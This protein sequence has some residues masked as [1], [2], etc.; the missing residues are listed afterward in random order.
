MLFNYRALGLNPL[1]C[2][3]NLAWFSTWI[4]NDYVEPGIARCQGPVLLSNKLIL[5]TPTALFECRSNL[6]CQ[7]LFVNITLIKQIINL[8]MILKL[9]KTN[10]LLVI[11]TTAQ[12]TQLVQPNQKKAAH[13]SVF[14]SRNT[15]AIDAS[16]IQMRAMGNLARIKALVKS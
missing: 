15:M 16:R 14:A 3:C 11:S 1:Y 6:F 13:I 10:V 2:D 8:Q 5:T 12:I 7:H 9:P 4:K